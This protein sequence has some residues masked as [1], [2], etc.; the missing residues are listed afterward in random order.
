[1][2]APDADLEHTNEKFK[3]VEYELLITDVISR[4]TQSTSRFAAMEPSLI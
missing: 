3:Y 4:S 1:M 2:S